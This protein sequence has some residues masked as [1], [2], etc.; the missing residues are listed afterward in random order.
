LD[1][2]FKIN[3]IHNGNG[4]GFMKG[5]Y[6]L[7]LTY[8]YSALKKQEGTDMTK[9]D[10]VV[11]FEMPYEDSER[12]SKFYIR[13]FG[14]QMQQLGKDMGEYVVAATTDTDENMMVKKP[15]AINGGFY[16]KTPDMPQC[17]SVV[18]AVEN[19]MVSMQKVVDAG[20][21]I[22]GE[23]MTI[24]GIGEYVAITDSEGNRVGMLQPFDM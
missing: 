13:V 18:I 8:H 24:P 20:G 16:P 3:P 10:P 22:L 21:K 17:P 7:P 6:I 9:M 2:C 5:L 11:H 4:T 12:L 19:I 14:W 23:P 1:L 15:G